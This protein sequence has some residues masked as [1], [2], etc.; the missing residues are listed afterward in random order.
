M[1]RGG[2]YNCYFFDVAGDFTIT[3]GWSEG[4]YKVEFENAVLIKRFD[5]LNEA[6]QAGIKL[7]KVRLSRALKSLEA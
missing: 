7:A 6:K 1:W 3:V 2:K 5:N 4:G